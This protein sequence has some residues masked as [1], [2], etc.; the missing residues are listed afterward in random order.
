MPDG[1]ATGTERDGRR[2]ARP[3]VAKTDT[4][5]H[6]RTA[7]GGLSSIRRRPAMIANVGDRIVIEATP[8][9]ETRRVGVITAV[10]HAD[11][12]PPYH[13]RWLES[14]Q[15]TLIFPGAEARIEHPVGTAESA[16]PA[17]GLHGFSTSV[18]PGPHS[19]ASR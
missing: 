2:A 17:S 11:G 5:R 3:T 10:G 12:A 16:T 19:A 14:G 18:T 1:A 13:V 4:G 15:T 6:A 9:N 7:F 8:L